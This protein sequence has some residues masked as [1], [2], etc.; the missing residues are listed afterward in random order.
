MGRR[1]LLQVDRKAFDVISLFDQ[2]DEKRYWL[3]RPPAERLQA[4]ELMRQIL[5]GIQLPPDFKA[6]LRLLNAHQVEYLLVGG[7]AV[8]YHGYPRATAGLDLWV[9]ISPENAEKLVRVPREF[10]FDV[11][12]LSAD[13]FLKEN[14]IVR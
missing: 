1:H 2:T 12:T 13:L 11:P 5:Y 8:G 14:Q 3:A 7:Y 9:R 6:F 4:L 10:G